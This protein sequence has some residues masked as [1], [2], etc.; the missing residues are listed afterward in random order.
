MKNQSVGVAR[1]IH[2]AIL[3]DNGSSNIEGD[4]S[5]YSVNGSH[6]FVVLVSNDNALIVVPCFSRSG[7]G[8]IEVPSTVRSGHPSW[9]QKPC[10][11]AFPQ[12]CLASLE[13]FQKAAYAANDRSSLQKPNIID[14]KWLLAAWKMNFTNSIH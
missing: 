8:R 1:F 11:I 9:T 10:F 4:Q 3:S 7:F 6:Y 12:F 13:A 14:P 2:P 5:P